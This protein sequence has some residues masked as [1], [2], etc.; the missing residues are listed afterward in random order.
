MKSNLADVVALQRGHDLPA[1]TRGSGSVPVIGSFGVTGYH[2]VAKYSGP[3][4]TIGRSGA[5]IGVAT[6]VEDDYWPLNTTLFVKDFKGNDPRWV[7]YLLDSIDF[8]AY[9]S[10]S[11]QP[12]L[13]RNYLANIEV[14]LAPLP[15]QKEIAATLGVLDDKIKSNK[16]AASLIADLVDAYSATAS[17]DLPVVPLADLS[18]VDKDTVNPGKFGDVMVDHFSLPAFDSG[19]MPERVPASNIMSNKLRVSRRSILLSRLNPRFNRTWWVTP[20]AEVPAFASTEFLA[21]TSANDAELAA[22]WL[23]LRDEFFRNE[24]RRRVTGT[25][26]SHQRVRPEDVLAIEVPDFSKADRKLKR[27]VLALLTRAEALRAESARLT[28]LRIALLPELL[29][30]RMRVPIGRDQE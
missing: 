26:G 27:A 24:L 25:S 2:D 18:V 4:V 6:Y 16:K 30:G 12:S 13:N 11:A 21:L 19:A 1:T 10:G 20:Q 17:L 5:S 23:A 14:E 28:A 9:N 7:Y 22:L 15:D 3:G 29:S 8:T